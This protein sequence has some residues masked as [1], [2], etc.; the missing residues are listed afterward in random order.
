MGISDRD[1]VRNQAPRGRGG[2][3][4]MRLISVNKWL[5]IINVGIFVI[6]ALAG[7]TH[8]F[9][10]RMV[11]PFFY[12]GH[13]STDYL[14]GLE[15]WRLITFQFLHGSMTHLFFNL[16]GLWIFGSLVEQT[17]GSKKY[18][19]FYLVCGIFGG[20]MYL[21]LNLMGTFLASSWRAPTSR[22]TRSFSCSFLRSR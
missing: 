9:Q 19:A 3:N 14:F 17:L 11:D 16:F 1:Y 6:A 21:L 20:L 2:V 10:G 7:R 15:V 8:E 22:P 12:Y 5:I 13:F 18:L 4:S